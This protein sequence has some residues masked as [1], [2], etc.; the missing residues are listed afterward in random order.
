MIVLWPELD[1]LMH[2]DDMTPGEI[3]SYTAGLVLKLAFFILAVLV[4]LAVGDLIF[5]RHQH[6]KQMKMSKQD[7]KEEARQ[8]DIA[9]EIKSRDPPPRHAR[10]RASGCSRRRPHRRRGHHEPDPLRGRAALRQATCRRRRSSPRAQD[11]IALRI[12]EIAAEH[13]IAIVENPPLARA[14]YTAVEVDQE[15]PAEFFS[16]RRRGARLRVPDL[17]PRAGVGVI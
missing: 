11:L 17:P 14:L 16:G 7:V 2:L 5:Q 3:G 12:R 9:P 6:E 4:P 1:Q 10:C 13:D 15:I 8:Q